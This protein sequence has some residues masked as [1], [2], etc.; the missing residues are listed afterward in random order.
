M[1]SARSVG[2]ALFA[3]AYWFLFIRGDAK[4][5]WYKPIVVEV[6]SQHH[7]R[8]SEQIKAGATEEAMEV[9]E[10]ASSFNEFGLELFNTLTSA[11]DGGNV[12]ISPLSVATA[13][14]MVAA[15]TT[16]GSAN[17]QQFDKT[18]RLPVTSDS[19]KDVLR[20]ALQRVSSVDPKVKLLLANSQWTRGGSI[21]ETY[22]QKLSAV[23]DAD[24]RE[25][26]AEAEP[27]NQ[28][29]SEKTEG[30]IKRL[31][32]EVDPLTVAVLINAVYFKG[33]WADKFDKANTRK[34]DFHLASG[35]STPC[36]M[37]FRDAKMGY[38]EIFLTDKA[39]E[40]RQYDAQLV[41]LPYGSGQDFGAVIILPRA[42]TSTSVGELMAH[43]MQNPGV[44]EEWVQRLP[45]RPVEMYLPR[46][47]LEYGVQDIKAALT[48]MGLVEPF[49]AGT[50]GREGAFQRMTDDEQVYLSNVFHKAVMEVNEEGTEAAAV[51]AAVM[52]T[53]AMP[54][55]PVEMKVDHPFLFAVRDLKSGLLLFIGNVEAP[56]FN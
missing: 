35:T 49:V 55:Q 54:P 38:R 11:A 8:P 26:T 47:K 19:T 46:F 7:T 4:S 50:A 3:F 34:M 44:W 9:A 39:R 28:W 12:L 22:K 42:G 37:M 33:E 10:V 1:F 18:L 41:E 6:D 40:T 32:D 15:G 16:E 25:L 36:Q 43:A 2:V 27:I 5:V 56:E 45:K 29:V 53:R 20:S 31:L 17:A 14:S 23:F 21:K 51:T 13:L 48:S 52:M 30:M 24:V